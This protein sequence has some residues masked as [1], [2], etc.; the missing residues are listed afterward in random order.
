MDNPE[1]GS[2][3]WV[4]GIR[5]HSASL[6]KKNIFSNISFVVVTS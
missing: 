4:A 3:K 6:G 5:Y 1:M 2:K